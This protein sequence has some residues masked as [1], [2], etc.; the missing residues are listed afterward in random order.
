MKLT[1]YYRLLSLCSV[2]LLAIQTSPAQAAPTATQLAGNSLTQYPFFEYVKAFN[3]NATVEVAIDPTRFAGIIGQ[4]CDIYVVAT[5]KTLQWDTDKTLTDITPG[6]AQTE[7]F[8]G[9]NIQ[10][11]T[12]QVTGPFQLNANAGI[13]LGVGYDVVL[14]CNQNA[15]LDDGDFIDGLHNEAGLYA[16]H[17][18]TAAGPLAVTET[19]YS[20][21]PVV[22][23]GFGIPANKLAED[24]YYP[25]SVATMGQLPLIIVSRGN[26]HDYRW[27]DHIGFHLASYGYIVMS[28]DNNTEPGVLSAATTTLGHT[29]AFIDQVAAGAIAGGT[30]VGHL[31]SSRIT[32]IGHSRGAEGVA[33]GYDR[34]FDGTHT[35][36]HYS[37]ADIKLISSML[38]T[39]FQ[40]TNIANPHDANY[41]LWTASGDSD[42]NGSASCNLCQTFHLH[43]R[44]TGHRQS[45]TVQGTGHGW[46]HDNDAAGDAFTGPCSIGPTNNLTHLIQLGHFL[47]LIKRYIEDNIPSIDFLT[48]QYESFRPIGVPTGNACI[49]VSHEYRDGSVN[50]DGTAKGNFIIDDY[51]TQPGT[52]V[53]S[54]GAAVTFDVENLTEDRLDDNNSN[55]TWNAS[56]P[57]NGATQASASDSSRGVVFDWTDQNRFYEW[58]VVLGQR[59]FTDN[60]YDFTDNLY[61][62]LRGAQGTQHPN[63]LAVLGDLTFSVTLRDTVGTS[64]TINIG[65]FGGG[66]EQPYQRSGGW[67]NEMETIR[68]RITDFLNNGSGLDLSD[69]EA[70]RLNVGPSWG[71]DR[72][73]IVVD[74]LM[75]TNDRSVYDGSDNG[76][77]HIT[78]VNGVHYDFQGAGEFITLR[79]GNSLQIQTRQT[80][81]TTVPPINNSHTGLASCVSLNTAVAARVGGHRVTYQPNLSGV[82]DPDGL[83]LRIDGVLTSLQP[84]GINLGSG[85][86]VTKAPVGNGIEIDF[87]DGTTLMAIPNWW[88]S[89]SKWYLNLSVFNTPAYEGTM[90]FIPSGDWL[91]TLPNGTSLGPR[92]VSLHQRYIDLNKTFANAWRVTDNTSLFDYAPGTSTATFT[93]ASWPPENPPCVIPDSPSTKP[94]DLQIAQRHCRNIVDKNNNANCVFDV[95]LTGE[96]SF[97]KAYL[98]SQR[99][100]AGLTKTIVDDD[101]DTSQ[102]QETVKFTA[103]V[104][105]T[106][107]RKGATAVGTLQFLLDGNKVGNPVTLNSKGRA[108]WSTSALETGDHK[109]SASYSPAN[110]SAFLPSTSPELIHT[111]I[112]AEDEDGGVTTGNDGATEDNKIPWL[113]LLIFLLIIIWYARRRP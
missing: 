83:Q 82:P 26:G 45:T 9:V 44:A 103:S 91:P 110:D 51:Q 90:G 106:A 92:P 41:H 11:N 99:I 78:T 29:D 40:G 109:I 108:L 67:H 3:E 21:D 46:F 50:P 42:V 49:V 80:A 100:E 111:V 43:D 37:M 7:T 98:Q 27:Y 34:L 55:F 105:R 10:G 25:T 30:L 19:Q 17:D 88:S 59:D 48:R 81:V 20:I 31:D 2:A 93:H 74:E 23:A 62:S 84:Q 22:G 61:L 13:G 86:R 18:T 79:K 15:L 4:T 1:N 57:F 64:S 68:I 112:K 56:D 47:P 54:S 32:W 97:A 33:I 107:S 70:I 60:P 87:P 38:P 95:G 89:Q 77:P 102:Y 12:F 72:G 71:S 73:R 24:L 35:P 85:G 63:T 39:D 104:V 14:D 8:S 16:V 5:K 76:D 96:P 75:L 66:L 65:A 36:T 113:I 101:K 53:S 94:I 28:H 58:E 6:G 69:I 52:G